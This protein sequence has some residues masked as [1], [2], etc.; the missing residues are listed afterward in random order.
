MID[1]RPHILIHLG[2]RSLIKV[3]QSW[4]VPEDPASHLD[5]ATPRRTRRLGQSHIALVRTSEFDFPARG[6]CSLLQASYRAKT[7]VSERRALQR[8]TPRDAYTENSPISRQRQ[9]SN[10]VP[11]HA[12][13]LAHSSLILNWARE[14][15][16]GGADEGEANDGDGVATKVTCGRCEQRARSRNAGDDSISLLH[17]HARG[18]RTS[19][20]QLLHRCCEKR[21]NMSQQHRRQRYENVAGKG[22]GGRCWRVDSHCSPRSGVPGC[23][24]ADATQSAI[25]KRNRV[26]I[27]CGSREASEFSFG[28]GANQMIAQQTRAIFARRKP[29]QGH[30]QGLELTVEVEVLSCPARMKNPQ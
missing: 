14:K 30:R 18:R 11:T 20:R 4:Y 15:E 27:I 16:D 3:L 26:F 19:N 13:R 17:N 29:Q 28:Y 7:L 5:T 8:I 22:T 1:V 12:C 24:N 2:H 21:D 9:I 25:A 23:T 6:R 10:C